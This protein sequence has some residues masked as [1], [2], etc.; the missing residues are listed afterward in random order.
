MSNDINTP[1]PKPPVDGSDKEVDAGKGVET[2]KSY[3]QD[4]LNRIAAKTREEE[5][6][7]AEKLTQDAIKK[8]LEDERRQAKLSEEER[9]KELLEKQRTESEA[10]EREIT[11]R[12]NR[13]DAK[14]QF[15]ELK[16]PM[17]LVEFVVDSD[18]EAMTEKINNFKSSWEEAL[19]EAVQTQLKGET[20]KDAGI[21]SD[22]AKADTEIKPATMI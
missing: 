11:I 9:N 12:E 18:K 3:T 7:K 21:K 4:D 20:P 8:A 2:P 5:R 22:S 16:L 17:K 1:D 19:K 6:Q 15:A 13:A 14:E 10:R